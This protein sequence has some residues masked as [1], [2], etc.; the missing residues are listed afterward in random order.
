[1]AAQKLFPSLPLP[2]IAVLLCPAL[3]PYLHPQKVQISLWSFVCLL[4]VKRETAEIQRLFSHLNIFIFH[5]GK[6]NPTTQVIAIQSLPWVRVPSGVLILQGWKERFPLGAAND[7][8]V[9][10]RPCA[11]IRGISNLSLLQWL[12]RGCRESIPSHSPIFIVSSIRGCLASC[13]RT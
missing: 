8:S 10:R 5:G 9:L 7:P 4:V 3:E 6:A 1:M 11:R 12:W 2:G 13:F